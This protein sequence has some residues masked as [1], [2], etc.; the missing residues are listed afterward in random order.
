MHEGSPLSQLHALSS[1]P[2]LCFSMAVPNQ[3]P[4]ASGICMKTLSAQEPRSPPSMSL[5]K[6]ASHITGVYLDHA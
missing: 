5:C 4:S 2:P 6:H 1:L 3:P